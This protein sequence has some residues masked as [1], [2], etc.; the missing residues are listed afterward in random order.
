MANDI[1]Q[2]LK[3]WWGYDN[4]RPCQEEIIRSVIAG[5]D[6]LALL[7]T[8]G[9][10][11][12]TYQVPALALDGL[13]L[14]I[15]PLIALMKDQVDALRQ[16]SVSAV[17]IHSGMSP[18]QIDIA[19][20]NCVYGDVK[21]LYVS[22]ER[23]ISELFRIRLH[24]MNISM[25]AIDEAHCICQWGYDFRPSY[26]RLAELREVCPSAPI[27]AL[28]ASATQSVVEDIM[29][30]LLFDEPRVVRGRFAR[31]N[32]SY[33][34]RHT[35]DKNG[36][37][38]RIINNVEGSGIVYSR[39]REG[40][41]Q[42]AKFIN[43]SGV[44]ASF[45]HGG[46]PH[47]ERAIRQEEWQS[48]KVRVICATNAFGMGID[49]SD[50][51]FVIH[52]SMCDS[53]EHYYQEAGRAGR[54]GKRAYA[55]L[56]NSSD[57]KSRV[58][59]RFE[60]EFPSLESVKEIY[61]KI[62]SSL[63]IAYGDGDQNAY[64]FNIYDFCSRERLF[65]GGVTSALKLLEMNGYMTLLEEMDNP[66]RLMF[67]VSRDDLYKVRVDHNE[68]D[69]FIRT[70]LRL[71]DGVFT[72]F[73][74][75]DE[76]EIAQWSGYSA[77]RVK[78]LLKRLW[79]MRLVRYIPSNHSPLLY[80]EVGRLP[81]SDIRISPESY[82]LRKELYH[83]RFED[84]LRYTENTSSCRSRFIETYFGD[85]QSEDCGVCDICIAAKRAKKSSN[86][87]DS[88]TPSPLREDIISL[89]K[90][91]EHSV[92]DLLK[93]LKAP[94]EEISKTLHCLLREEIIEQSKGGFFLLL[95]QK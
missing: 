69:H 43:D 25:I 45:Y 30:K 50:V 42:L 36:Q 21:L 59:K 52:Y 85:T 61:D 94:H 37:M 57:D 1:H 40:A 73:R 33:A 19:L 72:D 26:L 83:Q 88:P 31:K 13:C 91:G 79:Q 74:R 56:L 15:T 2:I 90:S 76:L 81:K 41:E 77:D 63:Q 62:C 95:Q 20:D 48:G 84:M 12:I 92:E 51:R 68:L 14:V 18:R 47:T 17:A 66:A 64:L 86:T 34:L 5:R 8:G 60:M 16:R 58:I 11:S 27:L 70:I 67:A 28:T 75:I 38:L 93:K 3:R 24:R 78:E 29:A 82:K 10:K 7:P 80:L 55:V 53:L 39:T 87:T 9:G 46:L 32:L 54:D 23:A 49:K 35:D 22:P 4:F 65:A 89:L 44:N 6:T 71:Y